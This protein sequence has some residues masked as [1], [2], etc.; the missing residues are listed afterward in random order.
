MSDF[1]GNRLEFFLA[2]AVTLSV[3]LVRKSAWG[4]ALASSRLPAPAAEGRRR[5]QRL[6]LENWGGSAALLCDGSWTGVR[7]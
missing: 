1:R 5:R 3:V 4:I 6:G 7:L 2:E